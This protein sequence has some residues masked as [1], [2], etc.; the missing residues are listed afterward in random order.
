[1]SLAALH[2]NPLHLH[3]WKEVPNF[4]DVITPLIA[5]AYGVSNTWIEPKVQGWL[6]YLDY[7]ASG[8]RS[9]MIAPLSIDAANT[10]KIT[11]IKYN[12]GI[13]AARDALISSFPARLKS[14]A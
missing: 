6:K 12:D 10:H 13:A 14:T 7:A 2:K 8:W 1:M 11:H 9:D 4:G 5:D 3:W